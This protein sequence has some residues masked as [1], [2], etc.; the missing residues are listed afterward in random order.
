MT[1]TYSIF[2]P[3]GTGKTTE[4]IRC[5]GE[6]LERVPASEIAYLSYTRAASEEAL[7]R[8]GNKDIFTGT[9]HSLCF[10]LLG[11]RSSQV[12]TFERLREFGD[13]VGVPIAAKSPQ[14]EG[15]GEIGDDFL[16][17]ISLAKARLEEPSD[18][19]NSVGT[20][21]AWSVFDGFRLAYHQWKVDNGYI[22]F[23]DM[24]E[25]VLREQPKHVYTNF[26]IDEAQDLS[27][28]QWRVIELLTRSAERVFI[29][30]DDDQSIYA[31]GGAD[32]EGMVKYE[33][34][35]G[36]KRKLLEQSHR[37][38]LLVH[39]LAERIIRRVSSRVEKSF[40]PK[41]TIGVLQ[42]H[43]DPWTITIDPKRDTLVLYRNHSVREELEDWLQSL[44]IPYKTES[45]YP[46]PL[47]TR[48][49]RAVKTYATVVST[50]L[51]PTPRQIG[52][53]A[54]G[55]IDEAAEILKADGWGRLKGRGIQGLFKIP[56]RWRPY[57]ETVDLLAEPKVR[58]SSI[59]GAKG[60]E[61]DHVIILTTMAARTAEGYVRNPEDEH[62]CWYVG[63]TRCKD[64]LDIIMDPTGYPLQ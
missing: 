36:A 53:M 43:T 13:L 45:G 7:R 1:H 39:A 37:L 8:V 31:W 18:T 42:Y 26:L 29:A 2:G 46:A 34:K 15:K 9:I 12:V 57:F 24:L 51:S 23:D 50:G 11:C 19:F 25:G 38:P 55:M 40:A 62:R 52:I 21:T 27:P 58:M 28:L 5:L 30:G 33:Q 54:V 44:A 32:P 47:D 41:D 10:R 61:A 63:V 48:V 3:P 14:A 6:V 64:Q 56:V 20:P 16:A 59:H 49:G 35:T 17:I 4:L 60:K 22:D